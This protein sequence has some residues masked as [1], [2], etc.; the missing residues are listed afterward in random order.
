MKSIKKILILCDAQDCLRHEGNNQLLLKQLYVVVFLL[1]KHFN[2]D[3][4]TLHINNRG[5]IGFEDFWKYERDLYS[6]LTDYI[7]QKSWN[8]IDMLAYDLVITHPDYQHELQQHLLQ[9]YGVDK[10]SVYSLSELQYRCDMLYKT[11]ATLFGKE[12]LFAFQ[13]SAGN[14]AEL[15]EFKQQFDNAICRV[16]IEKQ[17]ARIPQL[18]DLMKS[19]NRRLN[20]EK[21]KRVLILDDYKRPFFIGDSVH[22]LSKIKKLLKIFPE[23]TE[24]CLNINH[25]AAFDSI[26]NVFRK[27]LTD[28]IRI[29]NHHW[30]DLS[31]KEYDLVLCNNDVLLKFYWFIK[32][33]HKS[34][35]EHTLLYSFSV[36]DERVI[37]KKLSM[38]FYTNIFYHNHSDQ[39]NGKI[40]Q[41]V[42]NELSLLQEERLWAGNWLEEKGISDSDNLVLLL[43]GA[44]APDKIIYDVELLKLI[45]KFSALSESI[46]ILLVTEKEIS[47]YFWLKEMLAKN[48]CPNV[49]ITDAL[50][51]REVMSLMA[52]KKIVAVIGPC[53]GLMHLAD[54]VYSYLLNHEMIAKSECPILIT[55]AGK[56]APE[57]NYHP[58]HWWK[59][60][61]LVS[62]VLNMRAMEGGNRKQLILLED[63]PADFDEFNQQSIHAK[64]LCGA[65]LFDFII[66][67]FPGF[68]EKIGFSNA[69][70]SI[71]N[72]QDLSASHERIPTF[73]ISLEHRTERRDHILQQ[74]AGQS[75]FD[76]AVVNAIED[77]NGRLGLWHTI[78]KIVLE[79]VHLDHEYILICED[80]HEFTL[81]YSEQHLFS[82]INDSKILNADVLLGGICFCDQNVKQVHDNLIAVDNF[83]C[84]QFIIIFKSL[85]QKILTAEFTEHDCADF[86]IAALSDKKLAIYPFISTQKDFGYSDVSSGYYESKMSIS[87]NET[88][89]VI[90]DI[91]K[92]EN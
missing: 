31:L 82:G 91:I 30:E 8:D 64:D 16:T 57:R 76:C 90:R 87:F 2:E 75:A 9:K 86:K 52:D 46:K 33:Y 40:S 17:E 36:M 27:S 42:N 80:D 92:F 84:T 79:S 24:F 58:N 83:A 78:Q 22:W 67:K 23:Q 66:E 56:Q 73:I 72:C 15:A 89:K 51:L 18:E 59:N 7:V 49:V 21:T 43:H 19:A 39:L 12:G 71:F 26:V 69:G 85:F 11:A 77:R 54:G 41:S 1:K 6:F 38:D 65:M 70:H 68:I 25:K 61:N 35:P 81:N 28:R 50:G 34:L 37:S 53:T 74:F 4:F 47:N 32:Q 29:T 48:E 10:E 62:C 13:R 44:S 14:E 60:S 63:C 3:D 88:S 20:I 45:E 5:W 55:Y